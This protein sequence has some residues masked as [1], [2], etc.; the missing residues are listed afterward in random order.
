MR[1]MAQQ[2]GFTLENNGVTAQLDSRYFPGT[3]WSQL[4]LAARA[5]NCFFCLDTVNKVVAIW[6]K[7]GGRAGDAVLVA[8]EA[9]SIGY[10][11]FSQTMIKISTLFNPRIEVGKPIQVRSQLTAASG[12]WNV[13]LAGHTLE[14]QTPGGAWETHATAYRAG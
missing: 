9:G 3:L 14:S 8:P 13:G 2:A 1:K 6:P 5:A 11:R 4:D 7:T 10:P 12:K